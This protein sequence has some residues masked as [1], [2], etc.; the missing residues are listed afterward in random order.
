[1]LRS[2]A[3]GRVPCVCALALAALV[4]TATPLAAY[5]SADNPPAEDPRISRVGCSLEATAGKKLEAVLTVTRSTATSNDI[6]RLELRATDRFE[7]G[8]FKD[9]S[10]ALASARMS[11]VGR[12]RKLTVSESSAA[13]PFVM[14]VDPANSR[15]GGRDA[16]SASARI[17]WT[18]AGTATEALTCTYRGDQTPRL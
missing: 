18:I 16:L 9:E 5:S 2:V 6:S 4:T 15:A 3:R 17:V 10:V 1:M 12:G 7:A 13:S 14:D 8:A 11:I